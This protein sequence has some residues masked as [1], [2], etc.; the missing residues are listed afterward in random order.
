M[1][2]NT[3]KKQ[4][5]DRAYYNRE[6][7]LKHV[8]RF[9]KKDHFT[10]VKVARV[11]SLL[12]PDRGELIVD[13][14]SG[15]GTMAAML[16]SSG[17]V[18]IC[19]DYS[20]DSL[21]LARASFSKESPDCVFRGVCCDGRAMAVV[22]DSIDGIMA[23]DFT[24]HLDDTML[25]PTI[26]EAFRILKRGGRFVIYTPSRTHFFERLKKHNIVLKEDK[27]HIGLRTMKE[28]VDILGQSGFSVA[29]SFFEPTH[30]P[31]LNWVERAVIHMPFVGSLA[32]RRICICAVK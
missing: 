12:E 32:R 26:R 9:D 30:I 23:V 31:V 8:D 20:P 5:I 10:M 15:V 6:Y 2:D 18:T 24:E 14:G 25:M 21:R 13:L 1:A 3:K 29:K 19:M 28:Y 11:R 22:D 27:S 7:Y 17:A 16:A 4:T